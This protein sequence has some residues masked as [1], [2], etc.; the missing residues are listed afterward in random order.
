MGPVEFQLATEHAAYELELGLIRA[1]TFD[2][3]VDYLMGIAIGKGRRYPD[4]IL[5]ASLDALSRKVYRARRDLAIKANS[6]H[7]LSYDMNG[8]VIENMV[9]THTIAS[10]QRIIDMQHGGDTESYVVVPNHRMQPTD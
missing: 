1:E 3:R 7:G 8:E 10:I 4:D 5:S 9:N 6:I 2:Q